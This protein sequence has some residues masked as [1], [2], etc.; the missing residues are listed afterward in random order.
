VHWVDWLNAVEIIVI[1]DFHVFARKSTTHNGLGVL[2]AP[3]GAMLA[4]RVVKWS[5][6]WVSITWLLHLIV[7]FES[8]SVKKRLNNILACSNIQA[9]S[10]TRKN[11]VNEFNHWG[12]NHLMCLCFSDI[13]FEISVLDSTWR[14]TWHELSVRNTF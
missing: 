2:L 5:N 10:V 14:Y 1:V 3:W 13:W 7:S 4:S 9:W 12:S 6:Q 8:H 11:L